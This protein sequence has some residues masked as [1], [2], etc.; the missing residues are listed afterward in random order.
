F[1]GRPSHRLF[2]RV[3]GRNTDLHDAMF[4]DA[5]NA[6]VFENLIIDLA[7]VRSWI[8]IAFLPVSSG[9]NADAW[10]CFAASGLNVKST[11]V[12]VK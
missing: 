9:Q 3:C 12:F 5:G 10:G 2:A 11:P 4:V 8:T 6:Y 7:L 1:S